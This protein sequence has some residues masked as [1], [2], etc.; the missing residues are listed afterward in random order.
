MN[1]I[2]NCQRCASQKQ[3]ERVSQIGLSPSLTRP[4]RNLLVPDSSNIQNSIEESEA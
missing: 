1:G 2:G 3:A 4:L